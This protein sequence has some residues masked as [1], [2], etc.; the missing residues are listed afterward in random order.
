MSPLN[1]TVAAAL[2][3]HLS[4]TGVQV[5]FLVKPIP[6]VEED[7]DGLHRRCA[8]TTLVITLTKSEPSPPVALIPAAAKLHVAHQSN[9]SCLVPPSVA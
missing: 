7:D 1:P 5:A 9:L 2:P 3:S 8:S 6:P 4:T